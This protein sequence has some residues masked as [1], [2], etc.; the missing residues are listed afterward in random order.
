MGLCGDFCLAIIGLFIPPLSV[1]KRTGCDHN[2]LINIVLT[3]LGWTPG[4]LHAWYIILRYPDG[5]RAANMRANVRRSRGSID[6]QG[7][8]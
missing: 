4:I 7:Y 6:L 1:L 8:E 5:K 2:F 3:C